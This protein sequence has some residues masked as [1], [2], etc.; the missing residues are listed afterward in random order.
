RPCGYNPDQLDRSDRE[1]SPKSANRRRQEIG[2]A[3][4][5]SAVALVWPA[6]GV[7]QQRQPG[8]DVRNAGQELGRLLGKQLQRRCPGW[9]R[10]QGT[11]GPFAG[12]LETH[13]I[14]GPACRRPHIRSGSQLGR[15]SAQYGL[16]LLLSC[17]GWQPVQAGGNAAPTVERGEQAMTGP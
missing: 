4:P 17:I 16:S 3:Q 5:E 13:R 8:E 11:G 15:K 6:G 7:D 10:E 12:T 2:H 1:E 9:E 14:I